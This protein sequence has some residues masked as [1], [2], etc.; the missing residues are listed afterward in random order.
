M[1]RLQDIRLSQHFTMFDVIHNQEH[2]STP[3]HRMTVASVVTDERMAEGRAL[4][5]TVIEPLIAE[6][7][8]A[9]IASGFRFPGNRR[10]P[11]YWNAELG[12]CV[13]IAFHEYFNAGNSPISVLNI[14]SKL[15]LPFERFISYAGSEY[16]C[17]SHRIKYNRHAVYE[18]I[19]P[20]NRSGN[21]K[22][23][24]NT[25]SNKPTEFNAL[26]DDHSPED[27]P[28]LTAQ[29][30]RRAQGQ[31]IY[32]TRRKLRAQH[33]RVG[34]YFNLLDFARCEAAA[35]DGAPWCP[36]VYEAHDRLDAEG[37][38]PGLTVCRMAAELL[39]ET[40][41]QLG[42]VSVTKGFM[43][44]ALAHF[45][46]GRDRAALHT[47]GHGQESRFAVAFLL[48]LGIA[49]QMAVPLLKRHPSVTS[50]THER[51]PS[52][53]AEVTVEANHFTP[54]EFWGSFGTKEQPNLPAVRKAA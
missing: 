45:E 50:V 31:P 38:T 20:T 2:H 36:P 11:H 35:H 4:F 41:A 22:P 21:T 19:L 13:D 10:T 42:R 28:V 29:N 44:R 6:L 27:G 9:S 43:P 14:I 12:A 1:D 34:R 3:G 24:F 39:E 18:N 15:G 52:G 49:P 53:A 26:F 37:D 33:V 8:P 51:H 40:V 46:V 7:G 25:I 32:H 23:F 16:I 17:L 54:R 5:E 30:W 47:W 48:P